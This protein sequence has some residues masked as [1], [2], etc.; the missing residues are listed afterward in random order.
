MSP[1]KP[2]GSHERSMATTLAPLARNPLTMARPM[3]RAAPVTATTLPFRF[4]S[5]G[6][7]ALSFTHELATII[8]AAAP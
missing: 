2:V 3:P 5:S 1:E 8:H 7:Y 4:R 6:I